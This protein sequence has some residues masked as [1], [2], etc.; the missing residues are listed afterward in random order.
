M[1]NNDY[2][3][4]K[5][6]F[7]DAMR[8]IIKKVMG[9]LAKVGPGTNYF[10]LSFDTRVQG[11]LISPA[12]RQRYPT[13][14]SII[15]QHQYSDLVV[16]E[17]KFSV[18]LSF[19]GVE[20]NISVP[21]AALTSFSDPSVGFTVALQVIGGADSEAYSVYNIEVEEEATNGKD[22]KKSSTKK[23][24]TKSTKTGSGRVINLNQFRLR[25]KKQKSDLDER[26]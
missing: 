15:L 2:F 20:E 25:R 9:Q 18:T 14:L 19:G 5:R 10:S 24:T 11:V 4:Y 12:L 17:D 26:D 8:D 21:F 22:T 23:T 16:A 13:N 3:N 7:D 6:L 1:D